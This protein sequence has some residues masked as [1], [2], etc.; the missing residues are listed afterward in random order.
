MTG[1]EFVPQ[2]RL[3]QELIAVPVLSLPG[4]GVTAAH[5]GVPLVVTALPVLPRG[6]TALPV[7][8]PLLWL[9]ALPVAIALMRPAALPVG[10]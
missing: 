8:I 7:V 2:A 1:K 3:Q 6:I 4:V 5:P 9:P 10:P